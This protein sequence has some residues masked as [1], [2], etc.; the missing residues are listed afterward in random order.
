MGGT[1]A[2]RPRTGTAW[3][4]PGDRDWLG[5]CRGDQLLARH[6]WRPNSARGIRQTR[7]NLDAR[8]LVC[9]PTRTARIDPRY[10]H[11]DRDRFGAGPDGPHAAR[12]R[13]SH[14]VRRDPVRD[15]VLGR[16]TVAPAVLSRFTGDLALPGM[17]HCLVVALDD[18]AVRGVV[19]LAPV[20]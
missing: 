9:G 12:S 5:H 16:S 6:W 18:R 3:L 15:T 11:T 10:V 17:E 13:L 14:G 4:D 20:H 8:P 19:H 2:L 7:Y 1:L